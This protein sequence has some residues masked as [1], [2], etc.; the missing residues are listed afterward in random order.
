MKNI[1]FLLLVG[2]VSGTAAI[3][4]TKYLDHIA[5]NEVNGSGPAQISSPI[6]QIEPITPIHLTC[7]DGSVQILVHPNDVKRLATYKY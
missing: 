3:T 7:P 1:L 6:E 5:S 2:A 4:A